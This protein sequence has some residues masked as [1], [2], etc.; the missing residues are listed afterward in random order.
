MTGFSGKL[1][2]NNEVEGYRLSR[3][4]GVVGI[5]RVVHRAGVK[6]CKTIYPGSRS[7]GA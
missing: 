1:K 5:A 3:V 4:S 7:T 6:G 2:H